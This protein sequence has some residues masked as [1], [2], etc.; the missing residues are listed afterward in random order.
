MQEKT[1]R[2]VIGE[3]KDE[4]GCACKRVRADGEPTSQKKD[5]KIDMI[6][7]AAATSNLNLKRP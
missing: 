4:Q 7:L 6:K 3:S 1:G 2:V 5:P